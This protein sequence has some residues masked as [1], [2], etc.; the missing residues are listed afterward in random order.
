MTVLELALVV[1]RCCLGA[2]IARITSKDSTPWTVASSR[3][4]TILHANVGSTAR[5]MLL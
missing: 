3:A 5:I 2:S 4:L 1:G